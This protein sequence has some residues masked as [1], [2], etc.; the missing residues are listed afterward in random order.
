MLKSPGAGGGVSPQ[1]A[2]RL[3]CEAPTPKL[4]FLFFFN[5][6]FLEFLC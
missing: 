4:F 3:G 5:F 2:E 6:Y 1:L